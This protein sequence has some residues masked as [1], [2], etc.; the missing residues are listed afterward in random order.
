MKASCKFL[1]SED[2]DKVDLADHIDLEKTLFNYYGL[3]N[4][5]V[6]NDKGM[7]FADVMGPFLILF[8]SY[9]VFPL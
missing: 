2:A 3:D 1:S 8:H 7:G 9:L 6:L 5:A 4:K